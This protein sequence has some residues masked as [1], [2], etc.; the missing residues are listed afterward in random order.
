VGLGLWCY[1]KAEVVGRL[2]KLAVEGVAD[3]ESGYTM[4][5]EEVDW[6]CIGGAAAQMEVLASGLT[7]E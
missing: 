5:V 4:K 3:V 7:G 1:D 6:H 2:R